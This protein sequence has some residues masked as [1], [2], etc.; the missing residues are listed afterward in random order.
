MLYK[1]NFTTPT[2]TPTITPS[3]EILQQLQ[4]C[5]SDNNKWVG[6]ATT[7]NFN[8]ESSPWPN[9]NCQK[10]IC[11]ESIPQSGKLLYNGKN[12]SVSRV[13]AAIP[14]GIVAQQYKNID[15][16][17]D[18]IVTSSYNGTYKN[19][20]PPCY[21]VQQINKSPDQIKNNTDYKSAQFC[22]DDNCIDIN[23]DNIAINPN[24]NE[25][26]PIYV[27]LPYEGCGG[28]CNRLENGYQ[29]TDCILDCPDNTKFEKDFSYIENST[30]P[31]CMG[32]KSQY[33]NGTWLWDENVSKKYFGNDS[34][35]SKIRNNDLAIS[36]L[37]KYGRIR[38]KIANRPEN[39]NNVNYCHTQNMHFDILNNDSLFVQ[40][41]PSDNSSGPNVFV[42]YK[43]VN[44][45][46]LGNQNICH[47][48]DD[49][50]DSSLQRKLTPEEVCGSNL[51]C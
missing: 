13:G 8:D 6:W 3:A 37:T 15:E 47:A 46:I 21:L 35:F 16:W 17:I 48:K 42:R 27:I 22:K 39:G 40:N 11:R 32:L 28:N 25:P 36:E 23:D 31:G 49:C 14:W 2:T 19:P 24:T 1:Y 30:E 44:C 29:Y 7:T 9:W 50:W 34:L 33:N 12:V 18:D 45:N 41:I 10:S 38:T 51:A 43:K 20:R 5:G 4:T 26:F